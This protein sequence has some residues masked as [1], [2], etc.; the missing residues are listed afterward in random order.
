MDCD[1]CT[2]CCNLLPIPWMNSKE[3]EWCKKCKPQLG[4][5]IYEKLDNR[6]KSFACAYAQM[7]KAN[8]A[9][10]PDNCKIIFE[11]CAENAMF[12][13]QDPKYDLTDTAKKQ[14]TH[15]L[16][17]GMSVIIKPIGKKAKIYLA[18]GHNSHDILEKIKENHLR[19]VKR[20]DSSKLHNRS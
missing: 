2:L 9:L 11:R 7:E 17:E 15:F 4:C 19:R 8:I 16:N 5:S 18:N 12:G 6:C 10:R 13:T 3:G 1:G 14:I 20:Y